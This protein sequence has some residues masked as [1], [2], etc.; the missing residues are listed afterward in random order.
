MNT[1]SYP[2]TTPQLRAAWASLPVAGRYDVIVVG[3]GPAGCA[4]A[5]AAAR[6]GASTLLI[7][8]YG[9]LGGMGTAGLVPAFCPFTDREKPIIGGIGLAVL[10]EMKANMPHI[11]S[12]SYD[13]VPIDAEALKVVYERRVVEAGASVLFLT[14]FVDVVPHGAPAGSAARHAA[15]DGIIDG[16]IVHNKSGLVRYAGRVLVDCTGDADVAAA[17]GAPF[18][19]GDPVTGEL[20]P[21]TMCFILAASTISASRNISGPMAAD[22]CCSRSSSPRPRRP[23]IWT[24]SRRG[25]TSLTSR[26]ARWG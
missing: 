25:P 9:F 16:V 23:A 18:A 1:P 7:E 4:A 21:C 3:G 5:I 11:A 20:Q 22:T 19:K 10:E 12:T 17:A 2:G 13:W 24:S 8:Q 15:A 6:D 26:P 14:H